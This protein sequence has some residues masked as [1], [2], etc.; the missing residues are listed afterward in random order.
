MSSILY[1]HIYIYIYIYIYIF[2]YIYIYIYSYK[3]SL[4]LDFKYIIDK[5]GKIS[6]KYILRNV[7]NEITPR[8]YVLPISIVV[9]CYCYV[10]RVCYVIM[11]RDHLH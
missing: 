9:A 2:I 8:L 5:F 4:Y 10:Y 11:Y 1:T 3:R 7:H 6:I